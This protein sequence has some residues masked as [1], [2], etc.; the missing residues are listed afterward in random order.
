M[1]TEFPNEQVLDDD[2]PMYA[3]YW[4]IVDGKPTRSDYHDITVRQYK[5]RTGTKEIRRCNIAARWN[6]TAR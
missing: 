6:A 2:Y 4:Y 5:G 3:D 1:T